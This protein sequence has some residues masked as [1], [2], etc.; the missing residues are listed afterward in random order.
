MDTLQDSRS[1]KRVSLSLSIIMILLLNVLHLI[2]KFPYLSY[3]FFFK[4][5]YIGFSPST[6]NNKKTFGVSIGGGDKEWTAHS[7]YHS[8][9][10]S[11]NSVVNNLVRAAAGIP[12][13]ISDKDLDRHVAELL[14]AEA[15]RKEI[16]W[17]ELGLGALL[18]RERDS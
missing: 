7:L 15:K 10:M 6:I 4:F 9:W 16:K 13:D 14:A 11:L 18:G 12:S 17:S 5:P 8:P 3:S 2:S 1:S